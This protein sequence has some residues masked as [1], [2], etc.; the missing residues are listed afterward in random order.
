MNIEMLRSKLSGRVVGRCIYYHQLLGSTMDE[1]RRL[2]QE[3]SPEGT[4]V[5]AEEQTAG[6]GRFGREWVSPPGQNISLS[7]ILRPSSEQLCY[8]NMAATLAVSGAIVGLTGLR[9]AIK[10]PN[11]VRIGGRKVSGILIETTVQG[12]E[13]IHAVVGIGLNVNFDPSQ[14][15]GLADIATSLYVE[16]GRRLDRT[17]V[18]LAVL[19]RLDDLYSAVKRGR[20]LTDQWAAQIDTFGRTV[21]VRWGDR[22]VEGR[23]QGVDGHGNLLLAQ[24]DGSII[25]VVAGEVTLQE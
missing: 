5:V 23:A 14:T 18:I 12:G 9:P 16:T 8:L 22:L 20:S 13:P 10:W 25:T 24:P 15:P 7:A 2:A 21:K 11:D 4:V 6:R 1:A 19:E 17:A 3:G